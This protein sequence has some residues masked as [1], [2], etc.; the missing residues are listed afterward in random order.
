M[1]GR[2]TPMGACTTSAGAG[3]SV[4]RAMSGNNNFFF[5]AFA[6]IVNMDKVFG[7]EFDSGLA[8]LKRVFEKDASRSLATRP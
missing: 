7:K 2:H 8:D 1:R 4:I 5:K 6:T 3:V